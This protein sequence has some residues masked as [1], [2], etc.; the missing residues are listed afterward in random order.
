MR[1]T[2][3]FWWKKGVLHLRSNWGA[4]LK[5]NSSGIPF[6]GDLQEEEMR[7]ILHF[8]RINESSAWGRQEESGVGF[9]AWNCQLGSRPWENAF[10]KV[11]Y[12]I[13]NVSGHFKS[14]KFLILWG[15]YWTFP[16][17]FTFTGS[18]IFVW[19]WQTWCCYTSLYQ[20]KN[21]LDVIC[22]GEEANGDDYSIELGKCS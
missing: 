11:P 13:L 15:P 16:K 2:I 6:L 10:G 4:L 17:L 20:G 19:T 8:R 5:R 1:R 7:R 14:L 21:L 12:T 18:G 3:R 9:L 22:S